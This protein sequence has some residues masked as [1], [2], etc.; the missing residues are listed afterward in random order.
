MVFNGQIYTS[1]D[2]GVSWTP[3]ETTRN[4]TYIASSA[5]GETLAAIE[6]N[7]IYVPTNAG[8]TW[9][10]RG[11]SA[12]WR[13]IAVSN[14]GGTL[15]TVAYG[16]SVYVS[17][18]S[19][20]SWTAR[21]KVGNWVGVTTSNDG[22]QISAVEESGFIHT[23]IDGGLTWFIQTFPRTFW[24]SIYSTSRGDRL[25]AIEDGKTIHSATSICGNGAIESGELCDDGNFGGGD[26]CSNI[27]SVEAGYGC[28]GYPRVCVATPTATPSVTPTHTPTATPT[29]TN[30]ATP[31]PIST[32][33]PAETP[34]QAPTL[35]STPTP[36]VPF[37]IVAPDAVEG[38]ILAPGGQP[39]TE[40]VIVYLVKNS[41]AGT[42]SMSFAFDSSRVLS[43]G[44]LFF[45]STMTDSK[46]YFF[47]SDLP[48]DSSYTIRPY[49]DTFT[50]TPEERSIRTGQ[51][52]TLFNVQPEPLPAP[53]CSTQNRSAAIVAA[54]AKAL[55]LQKFILRSIESSLNR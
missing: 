25:W 7:Q 11:T 12:N 38:F 17:T 30:T 32:L 10:P 9:T 42:S 14:G 39:F 33:T 13:T 22:T 4:W 26:G 6:G 53:A 51:L 41:G 8:L 40:P 54:D 50:F 3:R 19:G 21:G 24:K 52:T 36:P 1:Q 15:V 28:S 2:Y 31:S 55:T 5:D 34:A 49:L 16:G 18:D 27:C 43:Q 20:A 46:G 45:R 47:F 23:S 35:T 37:Q 29:F 48:S 44:R